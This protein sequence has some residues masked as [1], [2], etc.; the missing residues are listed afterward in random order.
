MQS[1]ALQARN[2]IMDPLVKTPKIKKSVLVS[3]AYEHCKWLASPVELIYF[4]YAWQEL[5]SKTSKNPGHCA[6]EDLALLFRG[7]DDSF[8]WNPVA[9]VWST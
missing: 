6:V 2:S 7:L 4:Y 9:K 5:Q 3:N 1:A 8:S